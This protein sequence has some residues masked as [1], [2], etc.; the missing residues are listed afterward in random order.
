MFNLSE[1]QTI[2][3]KEIFANEVR[4]K[5]E[6]EEETETLTIVVSPEEKF[7]FSLDG[8]VIRVLGSNG[9]YNEYPIVNA[10]EEVLKKLRNNSETSLSYRLDYQ[11]LVKVW[12]VN[13]NVEVSVLDGYGNETEKS[14][15]FKYED[16]DLNKKIKEI[17]SKKIL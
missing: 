6:I 15:N 13:D 16:A 8:S 3:M 17:V 11:T 12:W 4:D 1:E 2:E 10:G 9:Y 7:E 5:V 14:L